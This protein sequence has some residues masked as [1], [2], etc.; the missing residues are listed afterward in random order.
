MRAAVCHLAPIHS[1]TDPVM[2]TNILVQSLLRQGLARPG[3]LHLGLDVTDDCEVRNAA[4][5]SSQQLY[6]VGPITRGVF[7]ETIAVP[8]IRVQCDTLA[9]RIRRISSASRPRAFGQI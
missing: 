2:S 6:A 4:G 5:Q 7:W 8:D 9:S 1:A 3:P